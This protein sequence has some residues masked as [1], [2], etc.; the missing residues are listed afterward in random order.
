[1]RFALYPSV[2]TLAILDEINSARCAETFMAVLINY[3]Y[4]TV[5]APSIFCTKCFLWA[6]EKYIYFS[7]FLYYRLKTRTRDVIIVELLLF[8]NLILQLYRYVS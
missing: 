4:P 3:R 1:M 2:L 8:Y 7:I 6:R 5:I